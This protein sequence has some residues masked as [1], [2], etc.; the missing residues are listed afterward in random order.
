MALLYTSYNCENNGTLLQY[1][2]RFGLVLVNHPIYILFQNEI[3]QLNT[4]NQRFQ[5]VALYVLKDFF[6]HFN[7]FYISVDNARRPTI[8]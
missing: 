8:P 6:T 4:N 1:T 5:E 3:L 2:A 7:F